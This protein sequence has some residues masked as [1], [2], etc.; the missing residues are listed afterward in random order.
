MRVGVDKK[1]MSRYGGI[2]KAFGLQGVPSHRL[3]NGP[4]LFSRRWTAEETI[5]LEKHYDF[6]GP[7][8]T[9]IASQMRGRA[10]RECR[11]HYYEQELERAF[12]ESLSVPLES[13][14]NHRKGTPLPFNIGMEKFFDRFLENVNRRKLKASEQ[15]INLMDNVPKKSDNVNSIPI[16]RSKLFSWPEPVDYL[17][18]KQLAIF[19]GLLEGL[20]FSDTVQSLDEAHAESVSPNTHAEK[21]MSN[22]IDDNRMNPVTKIQ[23]GVNTEEILGTFFPEDDMTRFPRQNYEPSA[24]LVEDLPSRRLAYQFEQERHIWTPLED[25]ILREAYENFGCNS[26]EYFIGAITLNASPTNTME[27]EFEEEI[28]QGIPKDEM[29]GKV[30]LDNG[31]VSYWDRIAL[32]LPKRTPKDCKDR[33]TYLYATKFVKLDP[34]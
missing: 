6:F 34:N 17:T 13:L 19:K 1:S 25:A 28:L 20:E 22:L 16:V 18:K 11:R 12:R 5:L 10:P 14:V 27:P 30:V 29:H 15:T 23:E 8:W 2:L 32:V 26:N 21:T 24:L 31:K 7:T 33:L 4:I 3:S 9:F